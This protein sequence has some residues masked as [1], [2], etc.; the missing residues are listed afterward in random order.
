MLREIINFTNSLSPESFTRNLQPTEGLHIQ[1]ELDEHG[2][3]INHQKSFYRKNDELTPFLQDCLNRQQNS[4]WISANKALDSNKK[5]HSCSAF[6]VAFKRQVFDKIQ[7]R[8]EPYF[9]VASEYCEDDE[10]L[11]NLSSLFRQ[12]AVSTLIDFVDQQIKEVE[13]EEVNGKQVKV[14][15][16]HYIY[17]YFRN[18]SIDDFKTVHQK[19]LAKR[20]VNKEDFNQ[21]VEGITYGV[22][23]YLTGYNT[24][25]PF[26]QHQT[27]PFEINNR[28][29][30]DDVMQLFRFSQLKANRQL[31]N[32]LPIFIEK[33]EL[34]DKVVSIF[35][36]DSERNITYSKIIT[37]VC[38][39]D[40]DLGNYYLLNIQG[41][42][43]NDFDF[44]SSF[45]YHLDPEIKI[46]GI[47][48]S[49]EGL[50]GA[51]I[52]TIFEFE[53]KIVQNIFENQLVNIYQDRLSM[54]YFYDDLKCKRAA[55]YQLVMKYR[56]A[57]YDYIYKSKHQAINSQMFHDI[58]Q[59]GILDLLKQDEFKDRHHTKEFAIK[60]KLDIWFSLYEY[61]NHS[62]SEGGETP[63][64]NKV[65]FLQERMQEIA[66]ESLA[67][68][69]N[70]NEFA[71]AAGQ[72]IYYLLNQSEA[73]NKSHALLEPFLQKTDPAQ[74]KIALSRMFAQYKHAIAFYKGRFEKLMAEV[75]SY[76]PDEPLKSL[77]PMILAGYFANCVI[78]QK[79]E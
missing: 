32:P 24:K 45:R 62:K 63:M 52:K 34:N 26:L 37:A 60:E 74:F 28:V 31:P 27:A 36:R 78:Y 11:L 67:H 23:D 8:V 64:A 46:Q 17:I 39:Q 56:K 59:T 15:K 18:A 7:D 47:F 66:N 70:D 73:G 75:L 25:K 29:S 12:F 71:Y 77:L 40:R 57:F 38:E 69:E 5:I 20:A 33:E 2:K 42:S 49:S 65:L 76:D 61:F 6:C 35:N 1:V 43:V 13:S 79:T 50:T 10:R 41:N 55:I 72:A 48:T 16:G 9:D 19:Y 4:I 22:P 54:R 68:V 51:N 14:A 58:M 53:R 30:S 3:L 21:D 44:V